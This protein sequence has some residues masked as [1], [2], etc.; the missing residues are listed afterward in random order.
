MS[1]VMVCRGN[2]KRYVGILY[3]NISYTNGRDAIG[4]MNPI[5]CYS[6]DTE[7]RLFS[8]GLWIEKE[9]CKKSIEHFADARKYKVDFIRPKFIVIEDPKLMFV[10]CFK[11]TNAIVYDCYERP[12]C[13]KTKRECIAKLKKFI[14]NAKVV[15]TNV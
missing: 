13:G 8:S 5:N 6:G 2:D 11:G 12:I 1:T 7:R 15:K 3:G 4:S 9:K 14:P 10:P